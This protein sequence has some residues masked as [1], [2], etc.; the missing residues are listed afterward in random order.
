MTGQL[1]ASV[2][3][4]LQQELLVC[5]EYDIRGP[6][7]QSGHFGEAKSIALSVK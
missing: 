4:R 2:A 6:H 1:H 5:N 3:L 7:S